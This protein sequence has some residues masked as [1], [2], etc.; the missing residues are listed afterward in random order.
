MRSDDITGKSV[1][2]EKEKKLIG[3]GS[4]GQEFRESPNFSCKL[5]GMKFIG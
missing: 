3:S 2:V 4:E 5:R 1:I